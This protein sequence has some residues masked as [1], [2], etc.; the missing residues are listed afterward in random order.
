MHTDKSLKN[1]RQSAQIRGCCEPLKPLNYFSA[2]NVFSGSPLHYFV[3]LVTLSMI[4]VI[5]ASDGLNGSG[6]GSDASRP[7]M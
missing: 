1:Q 3:S 5:V 4:P 7:P 6:S 2:F